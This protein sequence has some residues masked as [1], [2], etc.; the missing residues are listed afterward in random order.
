MWVFLCGFLGVFF[1]GENK[2]ELLKVLGKNI[3]M[4]HHL[5]K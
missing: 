4:N 1:K 2:S 5:L 3:C